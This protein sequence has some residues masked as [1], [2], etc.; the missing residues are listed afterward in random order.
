MKLV[1]IVGLGG[2]LGSAARFVIQKNFALI[3]QSSFPYPTFF[4]NLAGSFLIGLLFGIST[5]YDVL[6]AE[7]RLFL[8]TG[9]CGGFT[10][11]STFSNESLLLLRDGNYLYLL[12]YTVL[13][14]VLGILFTFLGYSFFK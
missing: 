3:I 9:F 1:L 12:L 6:P 2:F 4:I 13:S 11:F 7:M 14:V 5:K 10:T 8:T